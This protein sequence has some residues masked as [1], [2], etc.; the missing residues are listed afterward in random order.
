MTSPV[1]V[2][3]RLAKINVQALMSNIGTLQQSV[4]DLSAN[5][6]G[7]GAE[8]V[9]SAAREAGV[10]EFSVGR[11]S[12]RD[13]LLA[14]LGNEITISVSPVDE[15]AVSAI[16]GLK[17]ASG[18]SPAMTLEAR[19]VAVK[20]IEAGGGVSYGYT[21]RAPANGWLALVPLGYAD[22]FN[23]AWGNRVSAVFDGQRYPA[24]GR[25]A[26]D[27]HSISTGS[28]ALS[29]GDVVTYFG[30]SSDAPIF[31]ESLAVAVGCS[32]LAVTSNLGSRILRMVS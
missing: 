10:K 25:V 22:G 23:R 8:I 19:V 1:S 5:A 18:T 20:E 14:R 17:A 13:E 29:V 9:V 6:F 27:A 3:Q 32:P 26:M 2:P 24:V 11:E 15:V 31:A 12:E 7:H 30:G 16:Y 4:V 28:T 21:W